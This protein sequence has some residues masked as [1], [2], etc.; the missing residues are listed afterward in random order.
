ML[1]P[2]VARL[3]CT[4]GLFAG[5][6]FAR[7]AETTKSPLQ[8]SLPPLPVLSPTAL[9]ADAGEDR[10][11]LRWN[12]QWE[13]DRVIG[14]TVRQLQPAEAELT[15]EVLTEPA[16]VVHGLTNGASYTFTVAGVLKDGRLTPPSNL[17]IVTPRATGQ[18][19]VVNLKPR[20]RSSAAESQSDTLSFGQ[21]QNISF[22]Q[23]AVKIIF[24]DGQELIYD[25]FRPM[26]WKAR[27]GTHLLYPLPFGNGLDIGK[28]D[29]RGLPSVISPDGPWQGPVASERRTDVQTGTKHPWLTEPMTPLVAGVNNND[30]RPRWFAPTVDGDQVTFHYWQPLVALGYRSWN[31]VLVWETWWPIER[32][33]HGTKYHGLARLVEVEMLSALRDG[34][35][36]MLN[37]GFGPSG[38]R[39]GVISYST[40]FREPGHEVVDFSGERNRQVVFQ[41]PKPPR[42]GY[43]YHPNHDSLQASPLIFYDWGAGSLTITARSLYYHCANNSTSYIEQG[44]DGAWPNL[45]WDLAV[46]GR[47]TAVDTV[48]YLYTADM[49]LPLPQRFI[50]A[51]FDAYGEVSRRM[52]V[53]AEL[54]AVAM[55]APHWQLKQEGGPVSFAQKY[56]A[57][58]KDT[59][60]DVLAMYHDTWQ[61]VPVTVEDDYRL[62][63]KHDS[64]PELKAMNAILKYN[65]CQG[66]A[67][68]A[69]VRRFARRFYET[70]RAPDW[71][72][73][74]DLRQLEPVEVTA[75]IG[76]SPVAGNVG[77]RSSEQKSVQEQVRPWTWSDAVWH[78]DDG[79]SAVYPAYERIDWS[80][81]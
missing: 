75:A 51:R 44:A 52:G 1:L 10:A 61:A 28:F 18:A 54:G 70:H 21:F 37:N 8:A 13:D 29:D 55:D 11:Y 32:E 79:T 14:W 73:L 41:S 78:Y 31:F 65:S 45:A 76:D 81:E 53:Q 58:L 15:R 23:N 24:P 16:F 26:D 2:L 3:T 39:Q 60:I 7:G 62:D 34:Y 35:Q 40:G 9:C 38:S 17:A 56:I 66:N 67:G 5:A 57:K 20:G 30:A 64:N 71:I 74:R 4:I 12:P 46:A 27:N 59:G 68:N 69:A 6:V 25:N 80:R 47:R 49:T 48:E 22:G 36:V 50:N 77:T 43:G 72:E 63:E 19:K 33:R 42:R